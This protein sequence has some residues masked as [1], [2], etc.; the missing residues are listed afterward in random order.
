MRR[1]CHRNRRGGARCI[2]GGVLP[3]S[4]CPPMHV[5]SRT[6]N[7]VFDTTIRGESQR[8]TANRTGAANCR[9]PRGP[10]RFITQKNRIPRGQVVNAALAE[11]TRPLP[12]SED[13]ARRAVRYRCSIS[14]RRCG[15]RS[16]S[17]GSC[18]R[19]NRPPHTWQV[20]I[21][22]RTA[23]F[24]MY[25][26][27]IYRDS[28]DDE[29]FARPCCVGRPPTLSLIAEDCK[30]TAAT[31]IGNEATCRARAISTVGSLISFQLEA[32]DE[33]ESIAR[34]THKPRVIEAARLARRVQRKSH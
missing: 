27:D 14:S 22:E 24:D 9:L 1:F 30:H 2:Y 15:S 4:R 13:N 11:N 16:G 17:K 5:F 19:T 26:D 3:W 18:C 6:S 34:G 33:H 8:F 12:N 29:R 10:D 21:F 23:G 31:P 28:W 25:G 7:L 32:H 20:S